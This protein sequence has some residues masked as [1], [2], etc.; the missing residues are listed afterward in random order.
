M[1]VFYLGNFVKA[2]SELTFSESNSDEL[3]SKP[4]KKAWRKIETGNPTPQKPT[5]VPLPV[6]LARYEDGA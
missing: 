5:N 3:F 1:T 4:S 6:C 2:E